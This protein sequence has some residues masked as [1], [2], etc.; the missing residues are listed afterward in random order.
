MALVHQRP[1]SLLQT[2]QEDWDQVFSSGATPATAQS[3]LPPADVSHYADRFEF[4]LDLPGV[5][6]DQVD[7]SLEGQVLLVR[8]ERRA[9]AQ[10]APSEDSE[11]PLAQRRERR[12]GGFERRFRLPQGIDSAAIS[13]QHRDGVLQIVVPKLPKE[14]PVKIPVA[15]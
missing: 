4:S 12:L 14:Q 2:L 1:W 13:A 10:S 15:A 8:G 5:A 7:I 11:R 3:W 6:A 9:E